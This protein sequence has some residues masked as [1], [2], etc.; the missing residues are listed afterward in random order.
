MARI[1][2]EDCLPQVPNRFELVILAAQRARDL[3][4]GQ[5][6]LVAKQH[7]KYPI[8]ALREIG[9]GVISSDDLKAKVVERMMAPVERP[10]DADEEV[11]EIL[12]TVTITE[13]PDEA[14]EEDG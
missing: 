4:G 13:T 8:V 14:D 7:D 2:V 11:I 6:P 3:A 9:T 1:T 5:R 10:R 12:S